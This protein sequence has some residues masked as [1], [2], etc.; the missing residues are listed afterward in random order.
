[1]HFVSLVSY[2]WSSYKIY[3][4]VTK[5]IQYTE[6]MIELLVEEVTINCAFPW[7]LQRMCDIIHIQLGIKRN[8]WQTVKGWKDGDNRNAFQI[9]QMSNPARMWDCSPVS[10]DKRVYRKIPLLS[11][12][13]Q[14][15]ESWQREINY[16]FHHICHKFNHEC[17][18]PVVFFGR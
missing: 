13:C 16:Y 18:S 4:F 9:D 2:I 6:N 15:F 17:Q 10:T 8:W 5:G 12:L 11:F 1:M 14:A 7:N 3:R